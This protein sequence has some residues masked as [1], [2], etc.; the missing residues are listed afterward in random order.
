[1]VSRDKIIFYLK[2]Q[3]ITCKDES[4][5]KKLAERIKQALAQK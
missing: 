2:L 1:M 4:E 3:W 5:K